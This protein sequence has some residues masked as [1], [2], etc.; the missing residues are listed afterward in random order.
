MALNKLYL[1][2]S[3]SKDPKD[4]YISKALK[5]NIDRLVERVRAT[6][7]LVTIGSELLDARVALVLWAELPIAPLTK[8]QILNLSSRQKLVRSHWSVFLQWAIHQEVERYDTLLPTHRQIELNRSNLFLYAG[9]VAE[10]PP[11]NFFENYR[12]ISLENPI[13]WYRRLNK[14]A[15]GRAKWKIR[16][17]IC[18]LDGCSTFGRSSLSSLTGITT[19]PND[20][21]HPT[22]SSE[23]SLNPGCTPRLVK[24][25]LIEYGYQFIDG[26]WQGEDARL[27]IVL[28]QVFREVYDGNKLS[29]DGK[30]LLIHRWN[31]THL[32][33]VTDRYRQLTASLPPHQNQ[34]LRSK[35]TK[36][37]L[38]FLG[39]CLKSCQD[40]MNISID[41]P[42][43]NREG[44]ENSELGDFIEAP[45][46]KI[47]AEGTVIS[48]L[49]RK[50]L[51]TIDDRNTGILFLKYV[52]I[53]P[54]RKISSAL[55]EIPQ[56][57]KIY[58]NQREIGIEVNLDG[59]TVHKRLAKI[60]TTIRDRLFEEIGASRDIDAVRTILSEI[61]GYYIELLESYL[62]TAKDRLPSPDRQL[63]QLVYIE[64]QQPI[65]PVDRDRIHQFLADDV[66]KQILEWLKLPQFA[67][68]G[69]AIQAIDDWI[70][71][72]LTQRF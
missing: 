45:L 2:R 14:F 27:L 38:E 23:A 61:S 26:Q 22:E 54:S 47:S 7:P 6:D 4:W 28:Y 64:R 43:A 29:Q 46:A 40:P 13:H 3:D 17:V 35:T 71:S 1:I 68:Q 30:K 9:N 51:E 50:Y 36:E 34:G 70:E 31:G 32:Q 20:A 21:N 66:S 44:D 11:E 8:E 24:R 48:R 55:K 62:T 37:K 69:Q 63:Y 5:S 25:A 18:Q 57:R 53:D 58:P 39:Y 16:D 72:Q 15:R 12:N 33:L 10:E 56:D 65:E 41:T 59:A 49:I 67:A 60:F 42:I 19:S 52:L